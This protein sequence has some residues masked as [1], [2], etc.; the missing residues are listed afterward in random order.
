MADE[1][2]PLGPKIMLVAGEASGDQLGGRLMA[3]LKAK[4]DHIRFIGVGG[5]RMEREG[6]KSLFPMNEMSV[7]GLTEVVP[8]IP[9]LLKRISQTA[10]FAKSEKPD[11][12]IT[13]DA[14][15]FSFRVGKKL[16]GKGIPLVH[17]VAPS[18]W[19]WRAGRAKKIAGFLDHLLALL[20]FEPPSFEK[21][22]LP[23]TFI[24]HSA[25]EERH[26]GD[27]ERF[28]TQHGL[29]P[30]QKLLA[31]LPGS[32]NSEVKRLLPVFR[33]V[34]D[35]VATKYPDARIVVPTVSKVVDTI[36]E[37]MK[38]WPL[39]PIIVATDQERHDAF[40]AA[41]CALAASGTVS[42]ELAIAGVPH[43]IA[44]Q[45][46]AVT[47][48]IAKRLIKIDTVTIVNL[49]LGKKLIPE[50]LQD[51]CKAKKIIPVLDTLM[52]D[53]PERAAQIDGFDKACTLLGFGDK[54]PSEKAAEQILKIIA[55]K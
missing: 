33:K 36:T 14:P 40:S 35:D 27:G 29:T 55:K 16:K 42:L 17:Y 49:V 54:P 24:G 45:V 10:D 48:W 11:V 12:V 43:V 28:R 3:A 30:D 25:V 52:A 22:G 38:S 8:H 15:D 47:G 34:I 32:R 13:I 46:N 53:S 18:V 2:A 50:F 4:Q 26:D 37:E 7:M 6:L 41:D 1:T 19:A 21:E 39:D 51:K 44:Y 31:V 9:H 5:P 23:T 20:P